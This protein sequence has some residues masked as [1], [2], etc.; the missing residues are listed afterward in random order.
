VLEKCL[1]EEVPVGKVNSIADIFADEHFEA[2]GNLARIPTEIEFASEF[3]YR[4]VPTTKADIDSPA[5][6]AR[7]DRL[8]VYRACELTRLQVIRLLE[9]MS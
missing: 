3:R 9:E 7:K 6:V 1:A 2:R 5:Y 8:I 4:N